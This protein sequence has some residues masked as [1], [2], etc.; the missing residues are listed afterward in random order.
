MTHVDPSL[1]GGLVSWWFISHGFTFA[2]NC[3]GCVNRLTKVRS[4]SMW[5]MA[6]LLE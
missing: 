4:N 2:I 1:A 6:P 3:K 5:P